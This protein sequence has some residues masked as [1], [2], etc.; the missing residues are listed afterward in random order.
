MGS[1]EKFLLEFWRLF[2]VQAFGRTETPPNLSQTK[3]HNYFEQNAG[4]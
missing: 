4:D 2:E 1:K 3:H